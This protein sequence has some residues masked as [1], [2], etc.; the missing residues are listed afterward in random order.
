MF[1]CLCKL[2]NIVILDYNSV[3]DCREIIGLVSL[4]EIK[5]SIKEINN[6][7]R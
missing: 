4:I 2:L 1:K 3:N 7:E 6:N 5:R